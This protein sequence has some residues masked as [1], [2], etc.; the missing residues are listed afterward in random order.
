M[1]E[2][3]LLRDLPVFGRPR[4]NNAVVAHLD[5]R[6]LLRAVSALLGQLMPHD[7][8]NIGMDPTSL[9]RDTAMPPTRLLITSGAMVR[10]K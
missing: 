7:L 10:T 4:L 3:V 9:S 1:S 5:L 6:D 2:E 8:S